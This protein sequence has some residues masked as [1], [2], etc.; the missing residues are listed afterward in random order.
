[1]HLSGVNSKQTQP[2]PKIFSHICEGTREGG[3]GPKE[4][5]MLAGSIAKG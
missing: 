2:Q 4:T 5:L 3:E 1:M